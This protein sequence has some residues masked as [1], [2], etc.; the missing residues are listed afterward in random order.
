[1]RPVNLPAGLED[2][3]MEIYIHRGELRVIYDSQIISF[4]HL[5]ESIRDIF[6]QHM[7]ANKAALKSLKTDFGLSDANDMLM[8]YIKCNFGNFDGQPDMNE[9]GVTIS[10][11]WDCGQRGTC[12][13]E[14]KVCSRIAGPNGMLTKR[15]TEILFL[16]IEGKF[17]K[18]IAANFEVTLPTIETQLK[19]IREKLGCNNRIEVM[20]FAIRRKL[21]LI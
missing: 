4:D 14:G 17:D 7:I 1:M 16:L 19:Y 21:I 2:K 5:P 6:S 11:C 13:G 9:D 20:N 18:E 10:E 12:P 3:G 15:E 8:Q